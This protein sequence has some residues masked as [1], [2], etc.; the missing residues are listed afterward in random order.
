[1]VACILIAGHLVLSI[2]VLDGVVSQKSFSASLIPHD[3]SPMGLYHILWLPFVYHILVLSQEVC[4]AS[5]AMQL[6]VSIKHLEPLADVMWF[7]GGVT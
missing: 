7:S 1:M 2:L 5:C 3:Y 4:R 6:Q